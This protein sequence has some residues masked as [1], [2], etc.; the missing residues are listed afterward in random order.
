MGR[1]FGLALMVT[2]VWI[3]AEIYTQGIDH[4]FGGLLAGAADPVVPL[5]QLHS[6]GGREGKG[7][8]SSDE[9]LVVGDEDPLEPKPRRTPVQRIGAHVQGKIDSAYETRYQGQ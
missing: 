8:G 1:L 4:A 7:R 3:A 6:G 2:A 9:I 5:D